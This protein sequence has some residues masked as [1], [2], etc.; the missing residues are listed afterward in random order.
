MHENHQGYFQEPKA[1][2][3]SKKNLVEVR[4]RWEIFGQGW[5]AHS[6]GE[7]NL[8]PGRIGGQ[9]AIFWRNGYAAAREAAVEEEKAIEEIRGL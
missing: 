5:D 4:R 1:T 3:K 7:P 9:D 8:C 6:R 2:A